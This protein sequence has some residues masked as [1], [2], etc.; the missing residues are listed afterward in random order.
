MEITNTFTKIEIDRFDN[1]VL[2][3]N[4][5]GC[6]CILNP[7]LSYNIKELPFNRDLIILTDYK[8][9]N[10]IFNAKKI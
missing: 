6:S 8:N 7:T 1:I 10:Y 9:H 2:T 4:D 5:G 3:S